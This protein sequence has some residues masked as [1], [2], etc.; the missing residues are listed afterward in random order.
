MDKGKL[1]LVGTPIGNMEDIT[2]RALRVL[3]EADLVAAEDTRRARKLLSH[4][5]IHTTVTSYHAHNEREK[6][7]T[8]AGE[9]AA[10]KRVALVLSLIPI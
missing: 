9:V 6:A 7:E 8:I 2:L 5:D 4:H 3:R 1:F 10:G